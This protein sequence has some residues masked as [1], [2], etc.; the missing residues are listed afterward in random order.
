MHRLARISI[1][2]IL[3][4]TTAPAPAG[5]RPQAPLGDFKSPGSTTRWWHPGWS[6]R[7]AA[8]VDTGAL[9]AG[10]REATAVAT[11]DFGAQLNALGLNA[12]LLD[13]RSL[14]LIEVDASGA[15]MHEVPHTETYSDVLDDMDSAVIPGPGNNWSVGPLGTYWGPQTV[16][17]HPN[18]SQVTL[19]TNPAYLTQGSGSA[20]LHILNEAGGY[21]YPGTAFNVKHGGGLN[22]PDGWYNWTGRESLIY[23]FYPIVNASAVDQAPDLLLF[24][25]YGAFGSETQGGPGTRLN[26]W[27]YGWVS[28]NPL[29]DRLNPDL[30]DTLRVDW[31]TLDNDRAGASNAKSGNF[32]NGDELTV[33]FDNLRLV[34]QNSGEVRWT[35]GDIGMLGRP[36]VRRYDIYFDVLGHGGR[37]PSSLA[38]TPATYT[39]PAGRVTVDAAESGGGSFRLALGG[40][41][42]ASLTAWSAPTAEKVV[43]GTRAP[44]YTA[45]LRVSAARRESEAFQIVL[46]SPTARTAT[47]S[48]DNFSG[49]GTIT[50]TTIHTV[51][52]VTLTQLSDYWGR[53]G[54]FPDPL[55][56]YDPG[57]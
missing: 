48:I 43:P 30:S 44:L 1:V 5:A 18:E 42:A 47:A 57:G 13:V 50:G 22:G 56:P 11:I 55:M 20:H 33:Y 10:V 38:Y 46:L 51:E 9:P 7:I 40:P 45:P 14:R 6:Y 39:L 36:A 41:G 3:L 25:L 19:N 53:L 16:S 4:V 27:N 52:N 28:L 2:C 12:A 49:P 21:D 8:S 17:G 34:D 32:E 29:N 37:P 24:K 54:A 23:D 26:A 15:P 31:F 35:V